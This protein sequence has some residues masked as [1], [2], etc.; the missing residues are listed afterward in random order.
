V[1]QGEGEGRRSCYLIQMLHNDLTVTVPVEGSERAG[2]RA[3]I[4]EATVEEVLDVLRDAATDMPDN[5]NHR[6]RHN[7]DKIKTGDALELADVLRN[8]ALR[9]HDKGLSAGEKQMYAKVRGMLASELMYAKGLPETD[10]FA[11]LDG[12][13]AEMCAHSCPTASGE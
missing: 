10:A 13:L 8:L 4:S 9:D 5:W 7:R 12:V 1:E 11:L 6:V 2:I 3:V